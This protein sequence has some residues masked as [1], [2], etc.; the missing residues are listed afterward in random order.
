MDSHFKHARKVALG[1][2][3]MSSCAFVLW[4]SQVHSHASTTSNPTTTQL[5]TTNTA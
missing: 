5:T 3:A 1:C 4:T 2:L